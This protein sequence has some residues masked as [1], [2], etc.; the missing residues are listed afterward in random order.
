MNRRRL[1]FATLYLAGALA[2]LVAASAGAQRITGTVTD[3]AGAQLSGVDV[4]LS[5]AGVPG[6]LIRRTDDAGAYSFIALTPGSYELSFSHEG[7]AAENR[8]GVPVSAGKATALDVELRA[9]VEESVSV[10]VDSG[11]TKVL[12]K[13][14]SVRTSTRE[15]NPGDE[16][17]AEDTTVTTRADLTIAMSDSVDPVIAGTPLSYTVTVTNNGPSDARYVEVTQTPPPGVTFDASSGCA[18]DP[19]GVP[20]CT[21]ETIPAGSSKTHTL[22]LTVDPGTV[23]EITDQVSV[24]SQTMEANPGDE[25]ASEDTRV[26]ALADLALTRNESDANVVAGTP[27]TYSRT[28]TNKG[29]SNAVAVS[30]DDTI[31]VG[32]SLIS[33]SGC[34]E[35][36]NGSPTCTLGT[37]RAGT[38]KL[39]NLEIIVDPSTTD[40]LTDRASVASRTPDPNPGDE[41]ATRDTVVEALA[42]LVMTR[43]DSVDPVVAGTPLT[44]TTTVTNN[45][46]SN[47]VDVVVADTLPAGVSLG[48]TSGCAEDPGGVPT[49]SLGTIE[50][51][52][53]KK[54]TVSMAVL[55]ATLDNLVNRASVSSQTTDASTGDEAT[56]ENTAVETRADLV[57]TSSDSVDPVVAGLPLTYTV[58]VANNGPS[59]ARD[60]AVSSS[61]PPGVNFR[62]T[63]GCPEDGEPGGGVPTCTL[64]TIVAGSAKQYEIAVMVRSD[65]TGVITNQTSVSSSTMEAGPGE[66]TPRPVASAPVEQSSAGEVPVSELVAVARAW[67]Q[68]WADGE[69]DDYLGFYAAGFTPADGLSRGQ[70]EAQR[71]QRLARAESVEIRLGAIATQLLSPER[72]RVSFDQSYRS[73][74]YNDDVRKTLELVMEDGRWRILEERVE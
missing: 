64:G 42:D 50:V 14:A 9:V 26:D 12:T 53:T 74:L 56:T 65:A 5:G 27:L 62:S 44:Y 67:A 1:K 15:G 45:G 2:L 7:Y 38:S 41:A 24:T 63:T 43:S 32:A 60:V 28:V 34:A 23:G 55:S 70:W 68:A 48:V 66:V 52:T 6:D 8:Y 51:G 10:T 11:T 69:I 40:G 16:S 22:A 39:V 59:D 36:P 20:I 73:N 54:F 72:G 58:G 49:C 57:V 31:P 4:T 21:L 25:S 33:T 46:P 61:L 29:P 71:R 3:D 17:A 30:I 37:M 47:A 19:A 35:D 18:E 13:H